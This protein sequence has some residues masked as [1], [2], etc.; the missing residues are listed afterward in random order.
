MP[1]AH[2]ECLHWYGGVLH[3]SVLGQ[4]VVV[5]DCE[6]NANALLGEPLLIAVPMCGAIR[7]QIGEREFAQIRAG[8][9]GVQFVEVL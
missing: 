9:R 6:K 8:A 4:I 1:Y 7:L 5:D 2:D 3:L